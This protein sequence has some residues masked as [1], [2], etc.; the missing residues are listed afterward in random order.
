M[1]TIK[2]CE[3]YLDGADGLVGD[4]L[5]EFDAM[6]HC[7]DRDQFGQYSCEKIIWTRRFQHISLTR[8]ILTSIATFS[9]GDRSSNS[10]SLHYSLRHNGIENINALP[11]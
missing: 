8:N 10:T 2:G 6:F 5:R 11:I 9:G 7:K 4:E 3:A 1:S